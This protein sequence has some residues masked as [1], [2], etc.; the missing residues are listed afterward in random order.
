MKNKTLVALAVAHALAFPLAAS[1]H[2]EIAIPSSVSEVGISAQQL[3]HNASFLTARAAPEAQ[4]PAA[5]ATQVEE[6]VASAQGS[7][8]AS[9]TRTA[10]RT[11]SLPNP[12]TPWSPSEVGHSD[13]A[14]EMRDYAQHVASLDETR[15]AI[16]KAEAEAEALAVAEAAAQAAAEAAALAAANAPVENPQ[17]NDNP[18]VVAGLTEQRELTTTSDAEQPREGEANPDAQAAGQPGEREVTAS[19]EGSQPVEGSAQEAAVEEALRTAEGQPAETSGSAQDTQVQAE[20]TEGPAEA[21][22]VASPVR[23]TEAIVVGSTDQA[24]TTEQETTT[25]S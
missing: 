10:A 23:E 1:A 5:I 21:A 11:R 17:S 18:E 19:T 4:R 2:W 20:A 12:K 14:T 16:A 6:T 15:V 3:A 7:N 25:A 22:E 24:E 9:R 13:Y 8:V